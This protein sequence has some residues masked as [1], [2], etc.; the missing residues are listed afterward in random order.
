M[1]AIKILAETED[2]VTVSKTDWLALLSELEDAQ[3]RAAVSERRT[4]EK[5]AGKKS[6]RRNYLSGEEA[7]RLLN[8]E[9]A[10]KVWR[11]KR[12]ISQR[13]LAAAADVSPSYLAEI[14][15]GRKP[16]SVDAI[17]KLAQALEVRMEDLTT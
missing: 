5:A 3:D 2:A 14:E 9:S 1:N 4:H 12:G 13:A 15:A 16:G 7:R 6:A 17:R 8:G 10:I 11:E